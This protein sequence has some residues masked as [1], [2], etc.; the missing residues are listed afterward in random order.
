M[1]TSIISIMI[2]IFLLFWIIAAVLAMQEK[3]PSRTIVYLAIFSELSA[4]C[5]FLFAA[6]D[7]ALAEASVG[8][9]STIFFFVCFEKH[10]GLG[11]PKLPPIT[12]KGTT[13]LIKKYILPLGFTLF[14]FALFV[15]FIPGDA[16]NHNGYLKELYTTR[17]AVDVGGENAVT[18]IY[19][20]YRLYDT[21]F[22]AL[23]LVVAVVA[24]IH[25]SGF[26]DHALPDKSQH[27]AVDNSIIVVYTVRLIC[28]VMLL[29]GIYLIMNGHLSP[30]GGFQGGTVIA[31]FFICRYFVHHIYDTNVH[32]ILVLEKLVFVVAVAMAVFFIFLG[33]DAF[34]LVPRTVFL[35]MMNALIGLKVVCGFIVIFY[36]YIAFERR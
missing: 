29:F 27:S 6:P 4:I 3:R 21:L 30:G 5:F 11:V 33:L 15:Y 19:L 22:E 1:T 35:T 24:I 9:F 28:P 10:Y 12:V 34:S 31:C 17:F 25:V 13:L 18:S 36:R 14:L 2:Q 7:V 20:G 32:H 23:M 8:S 16:A 26:D